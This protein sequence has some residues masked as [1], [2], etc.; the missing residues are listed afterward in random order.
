MLQ[1][2][3]LSKR[4]TSVAHC[5]R[6]TKGLYVTLLSIFPVLRMTQFSDPAV[7]Y[8]SSR[9]VLSGFL[10]VQH[11]DADEKGCA[12]ECELCVRCEGIDGREKVEHRQSGR[13]VKFNMITTATATMFTQLFVKG[14]RSTVVAR[15]TA[16]QDVQ[17]SILHLRHDSQ[18]ISSHQPRLS[19][20]EYSLIVHNQG[21][22]LGYYQQ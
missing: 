20:A 22:S 5:H 10:H 4:C 18:Q 8:E 19:P 9:G 13:A 14:T 2:Y 6:S 1:C 16:G 15:W 3:R 12:Q 17:R 11:R 21:L 7:W